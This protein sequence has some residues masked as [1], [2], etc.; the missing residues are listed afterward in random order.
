[1]K[2]FGIDFFHLLGSLK[3]H[4]S[5][6]YIIWFANVVN[7]PGCLLIKPTLKSRGKLHMGVMYCPCTYCSIQCT[8]TLFR[9]FASLF[10]MDMG[11]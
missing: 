2:P 10:M 9:K 8:K 1:M 11:L 7:Y 4:H 5:V 3:I 6:E